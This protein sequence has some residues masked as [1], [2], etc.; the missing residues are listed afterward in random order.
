MQRHVDVGFCI[1][2]CC[3]ICAENSRDYFRCPGVHFFHE[4]TEFTFFL[5]NPWPSLDTVPYRRGGATDDTVRKGWKMDRRTFCT[6]AHFILRAQCFCSI[7]TPPTE[8]K[9]TP[10]FLLAL[11][12]SPQKES[13]SMI[14][15][16]LVPVHVLYGVW[17]TKAC[18]QTGFA[19]NIYFSTWW[20]LRKLTAAMI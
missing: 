20:F 3:S 2:F 10:P 1:E 12:C 19:R 15:I 11:L 14:E 5:L 6:A 16:P 17:K 7:S 8:E 13:T 18:R 4:S 9:K